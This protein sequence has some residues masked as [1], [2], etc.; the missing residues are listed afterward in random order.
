MDKNQL[1]LTNVIINYTDTFINKLKLQR[2]MI[3]K[4]IIKLTKQKQLK[5]QHRFDKWGIP[6]SDSFDITRSK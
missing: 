6:V 4:T 3:D 1:E 5:L 2:D